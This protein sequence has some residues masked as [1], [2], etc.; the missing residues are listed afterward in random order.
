VLV[1]RK[2]QWNKTGLAADV[3]RPGDQPPNRAWWMEKVTPHYL[4]GRPFWV[5]FMEG[6]DGEREK[7]EF[8]SL[9]FLKLCLMRKAYKIPHPLMVPSE[10][11]AD[12]GLG[13]SSGK[14]LDEWAHPEE[15]Q[16]DWGE[17]KPLTG[18]PVPPPGRYIRLGSGY[19]SLRG[20]TKKDKEKN[21]Q[22]PAQSTLEELLGEEMVARLAIK[23]TPTEKIDFSS[24]NRRRRLSVRSDWEDFSWEARVFRQPIRRRAKDLPSDDECFFYLGVE[25]A[26]LVAQIEAKGEKGKSTLK[27]A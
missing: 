26:T 27:T 14:W 15:N 9:T 21:R 16:G 23:P 6:D 11:L 7:R 8:V 17:I 4:D 20:R 5:L 10:I 1:Q 25:G 3:I 12:G 24:E 13:Y 19:Q 2:L 18:A 22:R